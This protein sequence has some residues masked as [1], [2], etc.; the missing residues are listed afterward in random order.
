MG[1]F[2][3]QQ[4][5]KDG[6]FNATALMKQWNNYVENLHGENSAYVKKEIKK[7]FEND[8]TKEFIEALI[9]EEKLDTQNSAYVKSRAREDRGGGTWMHPILFVKFAMWL[10][11]RF[12]VK[13]IKF[14]YDEMI[15]YRNEAGDAYKELSAAIYTIVDKSQ[16]PSRMAEVSKGINYVVFGEHRNMI[17]N[18]K[19]TEQD[20]RKLYEMERKVASLINDGFLKD[21]GQVMNYLRKKFQERTTPAVFVR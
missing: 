10:N 8:N 18:D 3:V 13:V 19:G 16:M 6:M 21:H 7:F 1:Q 20:Q 14:V 12:E 9:E 17:R 2:Q 15:K 5:T 11:P 4:R